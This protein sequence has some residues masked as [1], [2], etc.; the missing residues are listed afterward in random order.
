MAKPSSTLD[1]KAGQALALLGVV[2]FMALVARLLSGC[3]YMD[4]IE[5][6]PPPFEDWADPDL[7]V[8]AV[9]VLLTPRPDGGTSQC[10]AVAIGDHTVLT[11]KHCMAM[12]EI[13]MLW[14]SAQDLTVAEVTDHPM[15][16]LAL[17]TV[18]E[19]IHPDKQ[20]SLGPGP[21]PG[22]FLYLVGWGCFGRRNVVPAMYEYETDGYLHGLGRVCHGDSGGAMF[23]ED[24]QL[25]GI[26]T[27]RYEAPGP[28]DEYLFWG[29]SVRFQED[30]LP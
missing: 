15:I 3:A 23:N 22:D 13:S 18:Y 5:D 6:P 29:P 21:K 8:E 12:P 9:L 28:M 25:V 26:I 30:L 19:T 16:D 4:P 2:L 17:L 14:G 10:S 20:A 24:R 1:Y 11:A 7:P 27:H